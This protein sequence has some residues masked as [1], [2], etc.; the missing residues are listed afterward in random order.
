[1]FTVKSMEKTWMLD[2]MNLYEEY[3]KLGQDRT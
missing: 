1:M 3:E 2:I